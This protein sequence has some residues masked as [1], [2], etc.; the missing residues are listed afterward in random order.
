MVGGYAPG[1]SSAKIQSN[2]MFAA[3]A[4][5]RLC[6]RSLS[7]RVELRRLAEFGSLKCNWALRLRSEFRHYLSPS[8][9]YFLR[10]SRF[11]SMVTS[12]RITS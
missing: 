6:R 8:Y 1:G 4:A 10:Y 12:R 11:P 3:R 9:S 2:G 5:G 7:S